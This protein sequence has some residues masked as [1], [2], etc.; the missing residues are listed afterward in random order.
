MQM[1]RERNNTET[2]ERNGLRMQRYCPHA[3]EDLTF[4]KIEG[5]TIE[6]PRHHWMWD[7]ETG[8]CLAKGT[9]PLRVAPLEQEDER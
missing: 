5:G 2:I 7:A 8:S 6:C 3:G 1:L 9:V 4:A